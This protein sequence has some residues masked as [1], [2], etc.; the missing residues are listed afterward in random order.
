VQELK[1]LLDR[2]LVGRVH[3][4][5][6]ERLNHGR[7]RTTE[8][9][10]WSLAPHDVAVL[11]YL[12]SEAPV[13]VQAFGAA[14]LQPVLHDDVH[15]EL[16]FPTGRTA[17]IHSGWYWPGKQRGLKVLGEKGMVVF[18]ES[19]QSLT[20]HRKWVSGGLAPEDEGSEVLFRGSGEPLRLEAQHFLD[21]L[22]TGRQPISD[23]PSGLDVTRVLQQAH[24]QLLEGLAQAS[25][26]LMEIS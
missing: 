21:C 11:L 24:A 13:R 17:H 25:E 7:V 23:G 22:A 15:M 18:D 1:R 8:N 3:R 10:L 2:G 12:M 26:T 9:A 14:F 16:G 5:H 20:Y 19:D 6:M 4:V